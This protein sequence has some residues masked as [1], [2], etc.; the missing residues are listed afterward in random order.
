MEWYEED[1]QDGIFDLVD[2]ID[3]R[4]YDADIELTMAERLDFTKMPLSSSVDKAW[5]EIDLCFSEDPT[6]LRDAKT[7]FDLVCF[8]KN[9]RTGIVR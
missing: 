3:N 8:I 9:Q 7:K 4:Y 5:Y 1:N 2:E 6:R